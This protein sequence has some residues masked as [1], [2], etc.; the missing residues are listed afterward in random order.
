MCDTPLARASRPRFVA[1]G[2]RCGDPV[3]EAR[4]V[5]PEPALPWESD[6]ALVLQGLL[7]ASEELLADLGSART[8]HILEERLGIRGDVPTLAALGVEY[9]LSRER[10]RQ[11]Q[12]QGLRTAARTARTSRRTGLSAFLLD[13]IESANLSIET[14]FME[15]S[16]S[17]VMVGASPVLTDLVRRV[18]GV[19]KQSLAAVR[20]RI[21]Q[22]RRTQA[23]QDTLDSADHWVRAHVIDAAWWPPERD[24]AL[25]AR[26]IAPAR[27]VDASG[28]GVSGTF[29]STKM[30]RRVQYESTL[31]QAFLLRLERAPMVLSYQEQPMII[32]FEW[33]GSPRIYVPDCIVLLDDGRSLLVEIK[34]QFLML[35]ALNQAKMTAAHSWCADNGV[36]LLYTD[37]RVGSR[38]ARHR[39]VDPRI[40][41]MLCSRLAVG[42]VGWRDYL[43]LSVDLGISSADLTALGLRNGWR[44]LRQPWTLYDPAAGTPH[45]PSMG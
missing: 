1:L 35:D 22:L 24:G 20:S 12:E 45:H 27:D 14:A 41:A 18:L 19:P 32:P 42:P 6:P 44:V 9:G 39:A 11:I 23:A 3:G 26:R 15:S 4:T 13:P 25:F 7:D 30:S 34:P 36:G 38:E 43:A 33:Y 31:E 28:L 17:L 8:R 29:F 40:E 16:A 2:A 21:E 37:G 10:I 5:A